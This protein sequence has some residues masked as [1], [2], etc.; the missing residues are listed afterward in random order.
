MS[1]QR[2]W[3]EFIAYWNTIYA[4]NFDCAGDLVYEVNQKIEEIKKRHTTK[5]PIGGRI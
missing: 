2:R 5:A 3:K 1:N 4:G